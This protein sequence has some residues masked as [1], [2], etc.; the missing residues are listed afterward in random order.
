MKD[1]QLLSQGAAIEKQLA[2]KYRSDWLGTGI[3]HDRT[4]CSAV[5]PLS[6]DVVKVRLTPLHFQSHL[7]ASA[8]HA[9]RARAMTAF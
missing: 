7:Y 8:V 9:Y 2:E 3:A 1:K 4:A 6:S 5:N